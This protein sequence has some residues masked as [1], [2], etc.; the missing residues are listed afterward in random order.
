MSDEKDGT[1]PNDMD[2]LRKQ[3]RGLMS[4]G[5]NSVTSPELPR[6]ASKAAISL[7]IEADGEVELL[8]SARGMIRADRKS[9]L[10]VD[11]PYSEHY[12]FRQLVGK[13]GLSFNDVL[14]SLIRASIES[15][16]VF[17]EEELLWLAHQ[18]KS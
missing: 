17:T 14:R 1:K 4:I 5:A 2:R 13:H 18:N 9:K 15:G 12:Y 11:L 16:H 10:S 3:V 8:P 7:E 6:G